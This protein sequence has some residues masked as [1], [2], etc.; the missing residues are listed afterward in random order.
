M[1]VRLNLQ[2]LC[3]NRY[4]ARAAI[5]VI[6]NGAMRLSVKPLENAVISASEPP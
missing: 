5:A 6:V 2:K 1:I 4:Y 3:V